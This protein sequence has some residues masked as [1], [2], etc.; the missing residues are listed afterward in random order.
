MNGTFAM[1]AMNGTLA[2]NRTLAIN[3]TL[4]MNG[5]LAINDTIATNDAIATT[6]ALATTGTLSW[7]DDQRLRTY[8]NITSLCRFYVP[9]DWNGW[10]SGSVYWHRFRGREATYEEHMKS[11]MKA[12]LDSIGVAMTDSHLS[13]FMADSAAVA[14]AHVRVWF[15]DVNTCGECVPVLSKSRL[16]ECKFNVLQV[17]K[18]TIAT[19]QS[20]T[21]CLIRALHPL[22]VYLLASV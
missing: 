21:Q 2:I 14:A 20:R 19:M 18:S 15:G 16:T 22:V 10:P 12:A 4:A 3:G 9:V 13:S 1:L 11:I 7:D 17:W 6:G 8:L 5:A